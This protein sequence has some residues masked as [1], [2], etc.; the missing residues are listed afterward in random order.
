MLP[1]QASLSQPHQ[2]K[3]EDIFLFLCLPHMLATD[4]WA[5]LSSELNTGLLSEF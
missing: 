3:A 5:E 1:S 4:P 2:G